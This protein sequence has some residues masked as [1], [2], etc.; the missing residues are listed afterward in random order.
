MPQAAP[1]QAWLRDASELPE[2]MRQEIEQFFQIAVLLA[3]K[4][5]IFEGWE[6]REAAER[7]VEEG[8]GGGGARA[9]RRGAPA[10]AGWCGGI[11]FRQDCP[12][13]NRLWFGL[14]H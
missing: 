9:A 3:G 5:A 1:R 2:R 4:D 13:L 7:M 11:S 14:W 12:D 6:G 10:P 8:I